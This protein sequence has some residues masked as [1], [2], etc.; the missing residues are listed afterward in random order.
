MRTK[1]ALAVLAELSAGQWGLFTT[2]QA[3]ARGVSRLAVSRLAEAGLVVRV[4]HG[5]Y[6][7]AGVASDEHEAIRAAWLA[8]APARLAFERL[9]D[10]ADVVISGQM[11]ASLHGFG[12]LRVERF[13]FTCPGRRQSQQPDV[14]FR[15]RA[16]DPVDVTVRHGLPVTTIERTIAD[17]VESRTELTH[18]AGVFADAQRQQSLDVDRL[19][20]LLAPLAARNG[21]AGGDG[22]AIVE[23]L[24]Q[25]A[26]MDFGTTAAR[27]A[28]VGGLAEPVVAQYL[29][30]LV[31]QAELLRQEPAMPTFDTSVLE[32]ATRFAEQLQRWAKPQRDALE[33][34]N[35][36]TRA[37]VEQ[38]V[39]IQAAFAP[40]AEAARRERQALM[41]AVA[42]SRTS[43]V[44]VQDGASK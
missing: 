35:A 28:A 33:R 19:A 32:E 23:Q 16:I 42:G 1:S 34:M 22:R 13:E 31:R 6:R 26:G 39:H 10:G 2:A 8:T 24:L 38:W 30:N 11:A 18:V 20:A 36:G 43:L 37:M 44:Q 12:D 5:V 27:V 41:A 25:L 21:F 14:R 9:G 7:D 40:F 17:L 29:R 15:M 4:R 3:V